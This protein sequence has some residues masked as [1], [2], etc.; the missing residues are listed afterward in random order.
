LPWP[1][2]H[3]FRLVHRNY[4][5][6]S[7]SLSSAEIS[8]SYAPFT[9]ASV[10]NNYLITMINSYPGGFNCGFGF[11]KLTWDYKDFY[12]A[13]I[14]LFQILG[15]SSV[16]LQIRAINGNTLLKIEASYILI[17]SSLANNFYCQVVTPSFTPVPFVTGHFINLTVP[18]TFTGYSS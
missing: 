11:K 6:G 8:S 4:I 9:A 15:P 16:T 17:D 7:Y 13:E 14:Q 3:Y 1:Q 5:L 12:T 2:A 10:T 18:H